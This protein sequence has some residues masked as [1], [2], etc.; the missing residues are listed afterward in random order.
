M[1]RVSVSITNFDIQWD[2]RF[3]AASIPKALQEQIDEAEAALEVSTPGNYPESEE[4]NPAL[5]IATQAELDFKRLTELVNEPSD[6]PVLVVNTASLCGFA[7]QFEDM[8]ALQDAYGEKLVVL[9]G[10]THNAWHSDLTL[11]SGQKVGE[12]FATSSVSSPGLETYLA[13]P[14]AQI[15]AIFEGV[16]KDLKWMDASRR[17]YLKLSITPSQVQGEWFFIDTITSKTYKVDTPT[18]SEKRIYSA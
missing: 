14:P 3:V 18:A 1:D 10:D 2:D 12:E 9:A 4:L 6:K 15:K 5:L 13:L 7:P 11:L 17:G 16:V 8:Q